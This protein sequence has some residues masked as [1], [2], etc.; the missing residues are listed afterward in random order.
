[1]LIRGSTADVFWGEIPSLEIFIFAHVLNIAVA[2]F[3]P[4]MDFNPTIT[5]RNLQLQSECKEYEPGQ[6]AGNDDGDLH[7]SF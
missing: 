1:M 3:L 4:K 5:M 7:D 2:I 6:S